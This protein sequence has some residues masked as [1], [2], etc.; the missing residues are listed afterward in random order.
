MAALVTQWG[1]AVEA[2]GGSMP[3]MLSVEEFR[4][5]TGGRLSS[6]DEAV[7]AKLAAVSAAVR[8]YCGW[9][10]APALECSCELDGGGA[11]LWLPCMGVST[12]SSVEV[13]GEPCEGYQWAPR[14]ELRLPSRAPDALRCV[15]VAF[16]A[17]FDPAA[18]PDLAQVVAQVAAND[19]CAAPGLREEHTGSVGATYNMTESGVSGGVRLLASDRLALTPWRIENA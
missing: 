12:V 1:Y 2:D 19:L 8:S 6:S 9:H 18:V 7:E 16:V 14:G 3:P 4:T 11:T 5:L 10:V 13:A 15:S 17:G